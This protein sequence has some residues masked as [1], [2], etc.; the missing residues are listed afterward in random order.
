[1]IPLLLSFLL[2]VVAGLRTMM[3]PAM[4]SWAAYLGR[5]DLSATW[6]SFMG[7]IWAV[8][9]FTLAA[10]AELVTDQLP[11]TPSR[12]VPVQFGARLISA[13]FSGLAIGLA[14]DMTAGGL[15][16]GVV[17][18][19]VGTLGGREFRARLAKAFGKDPPAAFIE[20]GVAILGA[21]LI[22][23]SLP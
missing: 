18:A 16:A 11:S 8:A 13:G 7:S 1:M 12:T 3:A 5:L 17:G 10:A 6:M 20:D 19:V 9:I 21:I 23:A 4:V 14:Y 22:G 15:L 2:G